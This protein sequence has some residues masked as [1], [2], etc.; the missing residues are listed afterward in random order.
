MA[1]FHLTVFSLLFGPSGH[2]SQK[3]TNWHI[4]L[5]GENRVE[6]RGSISLLRTRGMKFQLFISSDLREDPQS[7]DS[8]ADAA[9]EKAGVEVPKTLLLES[10]LAVPRNSLG[11]GFW[12]SLVLASLHPEPRTL[13]SQG[14]HE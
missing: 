1:H 9:Q 3:H 10:H 5:F 6:S 11:I 4:F 14:S 2:L 8:A 13:H 7:K 12:F